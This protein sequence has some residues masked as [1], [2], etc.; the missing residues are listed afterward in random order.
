MNPQVKDFLD[1]FEDSHADQVIILPNNKDNLV[2]AEQAAEMSVKEVRVI[3]TRTVPQGV[4]ASLAFDPEGALDEVCASMHA[5][6]DE[7]ESGEITTA[8]LSGTRNGHNYSEGQII[9][10]HNGELVC[11]GETPTECT[12]ELL[13]VIGTEHHDLVTL[14]HGEETDP[15]AANSLRAEIEACFPQVEV[16]SYAGGQPNCHYILSVE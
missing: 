13:R 2:A 15:G 1:A 7:V 16:E 3:P 4:A 10:L 11:V 12:L 5:G 9:G 14:Y 8:I 6:A